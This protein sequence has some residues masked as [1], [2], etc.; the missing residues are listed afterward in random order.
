MTNAL[1]YGSWPSPIHSTWLTQQSVRLGEPQLG[2]DGNYWIESRPQ[3]KGRS[4]LMHQ[5]LDKAMPAR[6]VLSTSI[7]V[8]S[9]AH[10]YGGASY[11]VSA[12][13]IFY[14]DASDQR[15]YFLEN[16]NTE[17]NSA[18]PITPA[19]D[20]RYA[21][22]CFDE[23][24]QRL[25]AVREDHRAKNAGQSPEETNCLVAIDL[26]AQ[27]SVETL[28]EGHDFYANPRVSPDGQRLSWLCWDH[29]FMP[30]D[31]S[32][33]QLGQ[34]DEQG[35]LTHI[36][37]VA[38]GPGESI[39]QPQ[40][41]PDG[42][43]YLVSDRNDWWN[44]YRVDNLDADG[45]STSTAEGFSTST[46]EGSSTS[47]ADGSPNLTAVVTKEAEFAT[48]QWVFGM[49]TYSFLNA[50][51]I[52]CCFTQQGQWQLGLIDIDSAQL[53]PL[54]SPYC[55]ISDI[56]CHNGRAIFMA[57]STTSA[58]QLLSFD[59]KTFGKLAQSSQQVI[60]SR[61]L[62]TPEAETFD[63]G[64]GAK[65]H[66]FFYPPN[67]GDVDVPADQQPPLIVLCHGGPTGATE[68]GLNLKIQYWTSRGFAVM[69]VNYRGST[70]YGRHYREQLNGA[71]GIHDVEDV[72]AAVEHLAKQGKI[73]PDKV[74]I[75]GSSA[76]GYTV[77]AALTFSDTFKAGA[78]LYGIGDLETLATDTHKFESRYLD[79]LVGPYP[80]E[81]DLYLQRSPIHH[82]E[83][84]SCPVIFFQGLN[85][86]VVPPNQAQEMVNA[87]DQKQV[88]VAYVPFEGEGHGFRQASSIQRCLEAEWSF[89]GQVFGFDID[90]NVEPVNVKHLLPQFQ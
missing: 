84:L 74:A 22:F 70:G 20:F 73:D 12:A 8:H 69:D 7:S 39:F 24:R 28:A 44:L 38:G 11:L 25:I 21:D 3:E 51:E 53:T 23:S 83:Q 35:A 52:L 65:A 78:S 88:P 29:P 16:T 6:E 60:E 68:T 81:K 82:C 67:N 86:K 31:S 48:P 56:H 36:R 14:V 1:P 40:W 77:L 30:W 55:V 58:S 72:C 10:E 89:Y 61:Y 19:G 18:R 85:D 54:E 32:Q 45:F 15:I 5:P 33:C 76:G 90:A 50:H 27:T 49:S 57:S 26:A 64:S 13:G 42:Q 41:S 4:V 34:F 87:L 79:S 9:R 47:I 17:K 59:G 2:A 62:S 71:W 43:L 63:T 37:T 80:Q 66:G 46:A 75:K